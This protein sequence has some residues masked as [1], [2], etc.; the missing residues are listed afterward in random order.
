MPPNGTVIQMKHASDW[1]R[2]AFDCRIYLSYI[3]LC[4]I[5][6]LLWDLLE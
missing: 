1:S 5:Y 4:T 6:D 3:V 2:H